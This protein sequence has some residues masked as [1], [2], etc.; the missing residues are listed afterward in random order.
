[1]NPK[2]K[3]KRAV[4][5]AR[6]STM[7]QDNTRQINELLELPQ[8]QVKKTIQETGSGARN[9]KDRAGLSE[10][11]Q[12]V[13]SN[14][15]DT[16]LVSELSRLGRNITEVLKTIDTFNELGINCYIKQFDINTLD[17]NKKPNPMANFMIQILG[18]VGGL[19]RAQIM[20]RMK[21]GYNEYL[22]RGG[23]VGRPKGTTMND[24][25]YLEKHREP[26]MM[27][28]NGYTIRDTAKLSGVSERTIKKVRKILKKKGIVKSYQ[29]NKAVS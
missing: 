29:R 24:N 21:S 18:A 6:V 19:E 25:Q 8:F 20:E 7:K 4:I 23:H 14:D 16:V 9:N 26:A 11:L 27:L 13:Q 10:L 3:P 22:K 12:Y 2:T 5:Y 28:K 1:M 15:V 17:A